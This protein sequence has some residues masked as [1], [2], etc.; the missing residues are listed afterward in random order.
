MFLLCSQCGSLPTNV[1]LVP[2]HRQLP[3]TEL[4]VLVAF[5]FLL[6]KYK[7]TLVLIESSCLREARL[8]IA[9]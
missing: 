4:T 1:V 7:K 9:D 8:L 2:A 3:L 5:F 6:P